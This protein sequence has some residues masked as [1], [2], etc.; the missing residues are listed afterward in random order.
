MCGC[1]ADGRGLRALAVQGGRLD[2]MVLE[3]SSSR[4]SVILIQVVCDIT[5]DL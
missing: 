2:L 3:V 5:S 4:D 1:D